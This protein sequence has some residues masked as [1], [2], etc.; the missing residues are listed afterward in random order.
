MRPTWLLSAA[1]VL[2]CAGAM[3]LTAQAQ[4]TR[5]WVS[6]T[7]DDANPCSRTAP[8]K[9]FPGAY[10]KTAVGGEIDALDPGGFGTISIGHAITIDGGGG[11]VASILASNTVGIT[12]NAGTGD[13]VQI[14]NIRINGAG[15][16]IGTTGINFVA[17]LSLALKNVVIEQFS[18][19][20]VNFQPSARAYLYVEDSYLDNCGGGIVTSTAASGGG[21]NRVEI[22]RTTILNMAGVGVSIG[23]N[24][25]AD[26]WYDLIARNGASGQGDGV[27]ATGANAEAA[28]DF[29]TIM[30]NGGNGVH[31]SAAGT[32]RV[33]NATI[34][35]NGGVGVLADSGTTL[36]TYSNNRDEGNTG[37]PGAFTGNASFH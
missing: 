12:V 5:S 26:L 10:S 36:L 17:G 11:Q 27:L 7:G 28:V 21:F 8:C 24:T 15:S 4:T 22:N 13:H 25:K 14:Q 9:T 34:N 33:N 35:N 16:T 20:C 32:M 18:A 3:T 1:A 37:G 30:N 19:N 31:T 2:A 23:Q 29:S 6:G